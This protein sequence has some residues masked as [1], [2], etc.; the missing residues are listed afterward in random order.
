MAIR[1]LIVAAII[2]FDLTLFSRL[3]H[4]LRWITPDWLNKIPRFIRIIFVIVLNTF[5]GVII[6]FSSFGD[7][8]TGL[9][10][11]IAIFLIVSTLTAMLLFP[12]DNKWQT[13]RA[14]LFCFGITT[15]LISFIVYLSDVR[16]TPFSLNWSEGNR[17]YDYSLIFAKNLYIHTGDLSVPYNSPGRY[18]LWGSLFLIPGLPIWAHRLWNALLW[19]LTP[20][21]LTGILSKRID[22][23]LLRW[24]LILWGALFIIQGPVYPHLLVPMI[25]LAIFIWSDKLWVKII[26]GAIISYY[27]GISRYTWAI[28]PGIW[29]VLYDLIFDYPERTGGWIKKLTPPTLL[30]LVGI[31]P[32]VIGSWGGIFEPEQ[33]YTTSQPLL[34]Y[35]LLPNATFSEGILL[36]TAL[37]SIPII[38]VFAWLIG[39]GKWKLKKL[40]KAAIL[41]SV[42]GLLAIGVVAS[43]KIG[44]GGNLHNL[45]MYILTL[46]FLALIAVTQ[47]QRQ[48]DPGQF[49][50]PQ[51]IMIVLIILAVIPGWLA[52]ESGH[53]VQSDSPDIIKKGLSTI[54]QEVNKAKG[55]GEVLF[56]DQRQLLTFGYVKDVPLVPDYEKKFMMDQAMGNNKPYFDEFYRDLSDHRF[57][58]IVSD[59][60]KTNYQQQNEASSDENNAFVKWVSVPILSYYK[61]YFTSKQLGFQLLIPR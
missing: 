16:T 57:V 53:P 29:L 49:R 14:L 34:A 26:A 36:G 13:A 3:F 35:R 46:V 5:P 43:T 42:G 1:Y 30:G 52:I 61:P 60:Q 39:S 44:G 51:W 4:K 41:V 27:A 38:V 7:H 11:R 2:V 22:K 58:L 18:A 6:I 33:S 31:L 17:F 12:A 19:G 50:V 8:F 23:P 55:Q 59:I 24:G 32:G 25:L 10:L 48:S 40:A 54:I 9:Y 28:L 15:F 47:I 56:I 37:I 21:I 45:D 20:L